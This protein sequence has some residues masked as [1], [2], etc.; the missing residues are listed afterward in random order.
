MKNLLKI[1]SLLLFTL[2]STSIFAQKVDQFNLSSTSPSLVNQFLVL[3]KDG[4]SVED[5]YKMVTEWVNVYYNTPK[6][7]IKGDVENE[8]IR[9]QGVGGSANCCKILGE[10][11]CK[12]IRYS[13]SLEFKDNKLK[14]QLTNLEV[15]YDPTDPSN[16][17]GYSGWIGYD[18]QHMD[19]TKKNGKPY[20]IRIES[21][22]STMAHL[23]VLADDL[24]AYLENPLAKEDDDW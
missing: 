4:M 8:Y 5:G 22:E 6:E 19:M 14:F 12:D 1:I 7:V 16:A 18:P 10:V 3:D 20:R 2:I 17:P 9:I 24:A 15:Y 21:A 13:I 23:N 11:K